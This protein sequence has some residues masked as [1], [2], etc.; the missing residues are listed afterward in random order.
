MVGCDIE[1]SNILGDI[2]EQ[3]R[4]FQRR[5]E[6]RQSQKPVSGSSNSNLSQPEDQQQPVNVGRCGQAKTRRKFSLSLAMSNLANFT[7]GT[8]AGGSASGLQ[9]GQLGSTPTRPPRHLQHRAS[10]VPGELSDFRARPSESEVGVERSPGEKKRGFMHKAIRRGSKMFDSMLLSSA[11]QQAADAAALAVAA[12]ATCGQA[13]PDSSP[14]SSGADHEAEL[15]VDQ[16]EPRPNFA[17]AGAAEQEAEKPR[18]ARRLRLGSIPHDLRRALS[19][20]SNAHFQRKSSKQHEPADIGSV[21]GQ[22]FNS[23]T[24]PNLT[25]GN[26]SNSNSSGA[27]S[28]GAKSKPGQATGVTFSR[29]RRKNS[30]FSPLTAGSAFY[31][32]HSNSAIGVQ[33]SQ[34]D[35]CSPSALSG[36]QTNQSASF[37]LQQDHNQTYKLIIFGS[38]A[39][40]KT[41]LIQRFLYGHFPGKLLEAGLVVP[42]QLHK[43]EVT[44]V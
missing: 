19:L 8:S 16:F 1:S 25:N 18:R 21:L 26:N 31:H 39:V 34:F 9:A 43:L 44:I 22:N 6:A 23:G 35:K 30:L 12:A 3:Q 37:T 2:I 32:A 38:S 28:K 10:L 41:S 20:S 14:G 13:N 42:V 11:Q 5:Q 17:Q 7:S 15:E 29:L 40:G 33:Q 36:H 27:S 4:E 24:S